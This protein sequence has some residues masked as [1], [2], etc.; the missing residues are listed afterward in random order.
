MSR[1]EQM[2][3]RL[4]ALHPTHIDIIDDSA[5]H[6]GHASANGGGHYR[7]VIVS[8]SFKGM[9]AVNRHR[10]IYR[11]LG[12]MMGEQIHA[13]SISAFTPEEF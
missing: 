1:I 13:L 3:K 9:N 10:E 12:D 11:V 5:Q 2:R 4:D 6:A 8:E 7:L